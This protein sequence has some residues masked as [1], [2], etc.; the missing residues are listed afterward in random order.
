MDADKR[1]EIGNQDALEYTEKIINS[2]HEPV[3]ILYDDL[4]VAL[5]N[6]SFY[7]SFKVQSE[8]TEGRFIYELGNRQWDI[9]QL[10]LLLE[11][12]LPNTT[13]FDGY[14]IEHDFPRVGKR[15]VLLNACR[16]YMQSNRTKLIILT[17]KDITPL[18]FRS[19][20]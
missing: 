4:R 6:T 13:S 10:R 16:I 9:P 15:K 18:E 1:P 19:T 11:E 5:A 8:E 20:Y 17:I 12:I 2:V 7:H 14:E 3:I